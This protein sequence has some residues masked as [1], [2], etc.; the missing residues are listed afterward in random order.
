VYV[1]TWLCVLISMSSLTL[2][3]MNK[4]LK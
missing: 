1:C 3:L 2:Q 4:E